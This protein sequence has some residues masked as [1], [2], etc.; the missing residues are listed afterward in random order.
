MV[1]S[2]FARAIEGESWR[3]KRL[4]TGLKKQVK[5]IMASTKMSKLLGGA[6]G[7]AEP[8]VPSKKEE[9]EERWRSAGGVPEADSD[10]PEAESDS[11]DESDG[12]YG[13]FDGGFEGIFADMTDYFGGLEKIIGECRKDLIAAMEE[14]H[15]ELTSG[16]GASDTEFSTSSYR[17]RTTP[18][19]E[20]HFVVNPNTYSLVISLY[21]SC[22]GSLVTDDA[23]FLVSVTQGG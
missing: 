3:A 11:A 13:K 1:G 19:N 20:W 5:G 15:T 18:R 14:E 4:Q 17:V 21:I 12:Y 2:E 8:L 22:S 10:E 7:K 6:N 23:L 9:L 16:F